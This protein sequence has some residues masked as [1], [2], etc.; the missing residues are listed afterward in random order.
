VADSWTELRL[1][2]PRG[3]SGAASGLMWEL[4]AI[5]VQEDYLPGEAP[6]ARQPWDTGAPPP[7]PPDVLL[8]G[9]WEGDGQRAQRSLTERVADWLRVEGPTAHPVQADDWAES[10]KQGLTR[11]VVGELAVAPPWL[12]EAGDLVIEPG[13]AF[14]TGEHP[15][16]RRCLEGVQR[17]AQAGATC[18]DVGCGTG[19]LALAA[20]RLGMT[21][22]GIDIDPEATRASRDNARENSLAADFSVTPLSELVGP[23][24]LVVA[25]VYAEVLVGMAPDLRRLTGGRLVL[26]GILADRAPAV[27]AAL[28]PMRVVLRQ[29]DQDWVCLELAP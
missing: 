27:E 18:L 28:A 20:A 25:N 19:V 14:G 13:M 22:T 2:V 17:N 3:Q 24:D 9:W 10:W 16:T 15:T 6:P 23:Y 1:V 12:A 5:G 4:G 29:Q 8:R 11:V 7:Q 21:A 26:A